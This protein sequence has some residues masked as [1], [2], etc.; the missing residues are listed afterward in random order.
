M[1]KSSLIY[2]GI[3]AVVI[4]GLIFC[5]TMFFTAS[6]DTFYYT[7]IDNSRLSRA[8]GQGIIDLS[9]NG[10]M[11]YSY[12]LP[13]YDENGGEKDITFGAS[14]EL[15]ESAFLRLT[16]RGSWGVMNWAEV[17]YDELPPAVRDHYEAPAGD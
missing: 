17:Q 6:G 15:R 3:A 5:Y 10:G 11:D 8:G 2:I 14:R 7:Q 4:S 12:T 1:K 9:G 16:V 13:A